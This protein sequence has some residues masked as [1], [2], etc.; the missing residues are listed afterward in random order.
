MAPALALSSPILGRLIMTDQ[1]YLS[2]LIERA[3]ELTLELADL[4]LR[5]ARHTNGIQGQFLSPQELGSDVRI[6]RFMQNYDSRT[7]DNQLLHSH[8]GAPHC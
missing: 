8:R 2:A 7:M 5:V 3:Q 1:D 4:Q 6:K